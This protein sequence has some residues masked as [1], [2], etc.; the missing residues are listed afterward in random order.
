MAGP[1]TEADR[2]ELVRSFYELRWFDSDL[3]QIVAHA[4]PEIEMVNPPEA[5]QG[6]TRH[7]VDGLLEAWRNMVSTLDDSR[8]KLRVIEGHGDVV[9]AELTHTAILRDS[10]LLIEQ[11]EVHTWTFRGEKVIRFEW[12]REVEAARRAAG[13]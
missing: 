10:E 8:H 6:G 7:G 13:F 1:D 12:G 2:V 5:V 3:S 11:D 4:D 9:L